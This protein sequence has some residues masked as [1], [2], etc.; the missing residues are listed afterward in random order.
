MWLASDLI[1]T[2]KLRCMLPTSS[3]APGT[4]DADV[5]AHANDELQSRLVPLLMSI[6][7]EYFVATTDVPLVAGQAIYRVPDRN[8]ASK[9]REVTL[10]VGNVV[11]DLP[12]IEPERL[13]MFVAGATGVPA[14]FVLEAGGIR[15][16]PTPTSGGMSVRM[17]YFVRPGQLTTTAA[18]FTTVTA[19][20]W[21]SSTTCLVTHGAGLGP[22]TGDGIVYD[23]IAGRPP[24]EY[25]AMDGTCDDA[26]ASPSSNI[27]FSTGVSQSSPGA[28]SSLGLAGVDYLTVRDR[29]P[30]VQLPVE[31][32]SLLAQRTVCRMLQQ[33]GQYDKLDRAEKEASRLEAVALNVLTPRVDGAPRKMRGILQSQRRAGWFGF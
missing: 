3:S 8:A 4:A 33:L 14:G 20:V 16:I 6:N 9:L 10:I 11:I 19:A 1:A 17:R 32:H 30:V 15:L 7:E 22:E 29:S 18:D 5:L 25:V 13:K 27:V 12:R 24:F 21:S 26:V 28:Q 31:M 2:V 23:L